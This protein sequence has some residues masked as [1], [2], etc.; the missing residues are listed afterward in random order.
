MSAEFPVI[1][2]GARQDRCVPEGLRP[3]GGEGPGGR[4]RRRLRGGRAA[5]AQLRAD[6]REEAVPDKDPR[7]GELQRAV[8]GRIL[9]VER[10]SACCTESGCCSCRVILPPL[11]TST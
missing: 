10:W 6:G 5:K 8:F 1:Q 4:A 2:Q 9:Y 7:E 11:F 3:T